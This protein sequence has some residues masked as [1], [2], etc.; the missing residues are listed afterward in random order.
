MTLFP[1][2]D[3]TVLGANR[4]AFFERV[5][6]HWNFKDAPKNSSTLAPE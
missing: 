4:V 1:A 6:I 5:T 2:C 3:M